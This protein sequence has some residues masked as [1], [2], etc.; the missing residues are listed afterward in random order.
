MIVTYV[1]VCQPMK[2]SL[3]DANLRMAEE[4]EASTYTSEANEIKLMNDE[5]MH[6]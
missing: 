5:A 2:L 3:I 1:T 4:P 6:T